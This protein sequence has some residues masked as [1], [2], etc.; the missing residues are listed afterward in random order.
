MRSSVVLAVGVVA[1]WAC[2]AVAQ[3]NED[4][5]RAA[6]RALGYAGVEA[7]QAGNVDVASEKLEKAYSVLHVPSLGLWSARALAKRGKLVE[8]AERYLAVTRLSIA[9][10]DVEVQKAAQGDA[11]NEVE[12]LQATIP[13]L[14]VNISGADANAVTVSV[15]GAAVPPGLLG[16]A[17][18]VNPG[19]HH[20]EATLG[21]R[22]VAR[23]VTLGLRQRERVLLELGETVQVENAAGPPAAAATTQPAADVGTSPAT[24]RRTLGWVALGTGAAGLVVGGVTGVLVLTKQHALDDSGCR[25]ADNCPK[26]LAGDVDSYNSMRAISTVSFIAG[27]VLAGAGLVLLVSAPRATTTAV[28]LSP[29]SIALS[30]RF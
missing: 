3:T 11:L 16:E 8:A 25:N 19:S 7:Y 13:T 21:A 15:D 5:T 28:V 12:A 20:I 22:R 30:G 10:G 6:A 1:I 18:P 23:D 9:S 29:R 4:S 24:T 27:G 14:V 26:S 2:P 17:V